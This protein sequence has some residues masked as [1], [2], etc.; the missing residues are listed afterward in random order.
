[1]TLNAWSPASTSQV[2]RANMLPVLWEVE[3]KTRAWCTGYKLTTHY[4]LPYYFTPGFRCLFFLFVVLGIEPMACPTNKPQPLKNYVLLTMYWHFTC[5][6]HAS[7]WITMYLFRMCFK[8]VYMCA[9]AYSHMCARVEARSW[10]QRLLS[11][12]TLHLVFKT[13][14]LC[15]HGVGTFS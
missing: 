6:I 4:L 5:Y 2:L 7:V 12:I 8:P 9:W 15:A 1:M 10:C 14:S 13:G 11:S 3:D